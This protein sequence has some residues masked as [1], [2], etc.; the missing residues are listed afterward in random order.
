MRLRQ[1]RDGVLW[2]TEASGA[3][4]PHYDVIAA[5]L[6]TAGSVAAITAARQG[7]APS[8]PSLLRRLRGYFSF[9]PR[10]LLF[11]KN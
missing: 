3:D 6:G 10:F 2:E 8:V 7:L 5:G 4:M 1:Y 9:S 11:I